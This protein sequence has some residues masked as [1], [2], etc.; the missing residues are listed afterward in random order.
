LSR[1]AAHKSGQRPPEG[2]L[3]HA[4]GP[5]DHEPG[6]A[7]LEEQVLTEHFRLLFRNA[8]VAMLMVDHEGWIRHVNT[9]AERLFHYTRE[10]LMGQG[11]EI[12]LPAELRRRHEQH[13]AAYHAAP[14]AR[15]MG[16]GRELFGRRKDGAS[17]PIEIGLNP[18]VTGDETFVVASIVDISAHRRAEERMQLVMRELTHRS[19]NL[20]AVIQAMAREAAAF[21]P[22]LESFH[23][24]FGERLRGLARSHDLLVT[25][26]WEGASIDE[27][28]RSQ[29]AFLG[30]GDTARIEI[31]GGAVVLAPQAAQNLGLALHELATNAVKH[32]A[33]SAPDG[34]V[35]IAWLVVGDGEREQRLR[36]T[37]RESGAGPIE[38][39]GR[40]GFGQAVLEEIVPGMLDGTARMYFAAEGLLWDLD[41]DLRAIVSPIDRGPEQHSPRPAP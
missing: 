19:K 41:V 29:L 33:L 24:T 25:R 22:D 26:N 13:R 39:P 35:Q 2:A 18:M 37:W 8:P 6:R 16:E 28:V 34:K 5:A 15:P 20:L 4:R 30:Q 23:R 3:P 10:E 12:L 11:I 21:S 31:E 1:H 27:L 7:E 40:R 36:L 9:A 32:G 17:I 14:T 38:P